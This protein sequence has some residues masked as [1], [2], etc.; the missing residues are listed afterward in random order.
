MKRLP[1]LLFAAV[2][3]VSPAASQEIVPYYDRNI[4]LPQALQVVHDLGLSDADYISISM[5]EKI[6]G[7]FNRRRLIGWTAWVRPVSRDGYLA[8]DLGIA[9]GVQQIYT[10]GNYTLPGVSRY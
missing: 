6:V 3:W 8:I 2:F 1:P 9:C 5:R 10:K 7:A 4:C